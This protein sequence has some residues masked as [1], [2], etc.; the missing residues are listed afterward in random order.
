VALSL[1]FG[2]SCTADTDSGRLCCNFS[3]E[4]GF[5]AVSL[6]FEGSSTAKTD[7]GRLYCIFSMRW[8]SWR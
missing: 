1:R 8:A 4:L 5:V 7:L 2:G 3:N 6:R